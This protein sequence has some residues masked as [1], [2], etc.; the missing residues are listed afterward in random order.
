MKKGLIVI[1]IRLP[2]FA[3]H[4]HFL[5]LRA[6]FSCRISAFFRRSDFRPRRCGEP[7]NGSRLEQEITERTEKIDGEAFTAIEQS[8]TGSPGG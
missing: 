2:P 5:L 3:C 6:S 7:K 1:L 8:K 4:E